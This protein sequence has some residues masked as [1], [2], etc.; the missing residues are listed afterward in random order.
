M[1]N[2][3]SPRQIR[4]EHSP[5]DSKTKKRKCLKLPN[6]VMVDPDVPTKQQEGRM[7]DHD[8]WHKTM[9]KMKM[10]MMMMMM[11]MTM[12]MTMMEEEEGGI[13]S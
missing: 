9:M 7:E 8:L 13:I 6:S 3:F 1:W 10:K 2:H 12:T 11:M 5:R 4:G